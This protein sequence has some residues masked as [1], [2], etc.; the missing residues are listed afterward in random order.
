MKEDRGLIKFNIKSLEKQLG[1]LQATVKTGYF[2]DD[3]PLPEGG[4]EFLEKKIKLC[5]EW[6]NKEKEK[7]Q[8]SRGCVK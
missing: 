5:K 7:L 2:L 4:K 8:E 6:I 1:Y 3:T